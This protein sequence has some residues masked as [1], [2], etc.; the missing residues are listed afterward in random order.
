MKKQILTGGLVLLTALPLLAISLKAQNRGSHGAQAPM[1]R[2]SH[3][4]QGGH[5]GRGMGNRIRHRYVMRGPGIPADYRNVVNPLPPSREA[6][7]AG[8]QVY[9]EHCASCHGAKGMGDGEA[10]KSLSPPPANIA[11]IMRMP[12]MA[13]DSFLLWT[14]VE[15]GVPLKTAM[16]AFGKVL[17]QKEHWQ[18][19]HFLRGGLGR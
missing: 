9:V 5:M 16:P 15:G 19:I 13:T 6:V 3:M 7:E 10:G 11:H 8:R 12:M 4:G 1:E 18:L 14:I 17:S 2:G